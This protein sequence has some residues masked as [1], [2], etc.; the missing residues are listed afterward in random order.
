MV[1]AIV[2]RRGAA[3]VVILDWS[4][5]GGSPGKGYL[6]FERMRGHIAR[7]IAPLPAII[8]DDTTYDRRWLSEPEAQRTIVIR[9]F[10]M[11]EMHDGGVFLDQLLAAGTPVFNS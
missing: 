3:R 9:G 10:M 1:A 5:G 2:R 4:I 7:A 6:S 11:D 8:A